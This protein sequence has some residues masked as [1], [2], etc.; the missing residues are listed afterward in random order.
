MPRAQQRDLAKKKERSGTYYLWNIKVVP[1]QFC[2]LSK[3]HRKVPIIF[4]PMRVRGLCN[5]YS[6]RK[7]LWLHLREDK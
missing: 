5:K 3:G 2:Y 7:P 1:S 6:E 4:L